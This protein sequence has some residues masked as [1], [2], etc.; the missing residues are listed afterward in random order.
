MK[1]NISHILSCLFVLLTLVSCDFSAKE[2]EYEDVLGTYN[3]FAS[4]TITVGADEGFDWPALG[5]FNYGDT[6]LQ[7]TIL[8]DTAFM[9]ADVDTEDRM[10]FMAMTSSVKL[11]DSEFSFLMLDVENI[12]TTIKGNRVVSWDVYEIPTASTILP[13]KTLYVPVDEIEIYVVYPD[14]TTAEV[15]AKGYLATSL[16]NYSL[17]M[18]LMIEEAPGLLT[19]GCTLWLGFSGNMN[20]RHILT[21][22][23]L[24]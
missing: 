5:H 15:M 23:D 20:S 8:P 9:I 7:T 3:G 6:L 10:S 24:Y 16:V 19:P 21:K 17:D 2:I 4:A 11:L 1:R 12:R 14:E 18:H 22:D 13:L